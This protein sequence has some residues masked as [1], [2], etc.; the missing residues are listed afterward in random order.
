MASTPHPRNVHNNALLGSLLLICLAACGSLESLEKASKTPAPEWVVN[1]T[2]PR[3]PQVGENRQYFIGRSTATNILDER[4]GI[5]EAMQDAAYSIAA[6]AAEGVG[7]SWVIVDSRSGDRVRGADRAQG[8]AERRIEVDINQLV[9]G[10]RQEDGYWEQWKLRGKDIDGTVRRYKYWVL[11]S[12]PIE[13][14]ERLR[15]QVKKK[16][17]SG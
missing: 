12:F 6:A 11:V 17:S 1:L 7:G 10:L 13:E 16:T 3:P 14:L 15:E 2:P 4:M 5:N 8:S 9:S